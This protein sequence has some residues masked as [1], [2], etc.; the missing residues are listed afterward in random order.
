MTDERSFPLKALSKEGIAAALQKA[1]RYRLL[2]E[3]WQAESICRDILR[4]DEQ[5]EQALVMLV[6]AISD[7]FRT[8]GGQRME[9]ARQVLGQIG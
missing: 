5:H 1:E 6:L 9:E 7:E 2:N 3:P 4:A 8:E